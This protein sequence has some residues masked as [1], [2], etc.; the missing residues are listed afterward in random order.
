MQKNTKKSIKYFTN[1]IVFN[2]FYVNGLK[3]KNDLIYI[4]LWTTSDIEPFRFLSMG[5]ES[6]ISKKCVFQNCFVT[7]NR[8][9]FADVTE[10]D[11]IMFNMMN[12]GINVQALPSKRS[13]HQRYVFVALYPAGYHEISGGFNGFFNLT[14]TYKLSS[15][16]SFTHI[17]VKNKHDELIGPKIDM[18]WIDI[19]DMKPTSS[20]VIHKLRKKKTAAMW[21]VS[22]CLAKSNRHSFV[23]SLQREL[24]KYNHTLDIFGKCGNMNCPDNESLDECFALI[25]SDYYFY[26]AFENSLSEDYVTEKVCHALEHFAVPV[27]FGGANYTRY[28]HFFAVYLVQLNVIIIH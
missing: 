13:I 17:T 8:T 3:E 12:L 24:T 14:W 20:Y 28:L 4:L 25:E 26:L 19:N 2:I 21:I 23:T 10:F 5:Q 16:V 18:H 1:I 9:H 11:V 27:V 15:D 6:F 7:N 22:N